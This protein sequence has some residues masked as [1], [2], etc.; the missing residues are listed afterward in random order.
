MMQPGHMTRYPTARWFKED[1]RQTCQNGCGR[2]SIGI[3][4]SYRNEDLA[5]MC[6]RCAKAIIARAT[7]SDADIRAALIG[8]DTK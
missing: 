4:M 5:R 6:S 1:S 8:E 7:K 3:L 2:R